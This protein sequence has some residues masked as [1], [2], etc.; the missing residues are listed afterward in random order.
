MYVCTYRGMYSADE[1]KHVRQSTYFAVLAEGICRSQVPVFRKNGCQGKVSCKCPSGGLSGFVFI[2]LRMPSL[3]LI[4]AALPRQMGSIE[5]PTDGDQSR[6]QT[7][8]LMMVLTRS[9]AS[10]KSLYCH[11]PESPDSRA[12][13]PHRGLVGCCGL[14]LRGD[15]GPCGVMRNTVMRLTMM[16]IVA[17]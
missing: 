5:L 14:R 9:V 8:T 16:I 13:V 1:G 4:S 17:S 7:R 6:E 10:S 12:Q 15:A 2:A 3:S 11:M